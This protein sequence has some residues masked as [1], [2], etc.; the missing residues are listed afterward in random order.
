MVPR[1]EGYTYGVWDLSLVQ[2]PFSVA[3]CQTLALRFATFASL[4]AALLGS[5]SHSLSLSLSLSHSFSLSLTQV[6]LVAGLADTLRAA[7]RRVFGPSAAAAALEGSKKFM[8]DVCYKYGVDTG[9]WSI[10]PLDV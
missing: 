4:Y 6:P 7:G 5:V 9:G 10:V 8:K 3:P 1:T 2:G